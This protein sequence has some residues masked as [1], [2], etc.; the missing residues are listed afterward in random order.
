M[1]KP[2]NKRTQDFVVSL[3]WETIRKIKKIARQRSTSV[4]ALL[5]RQMELLATEDAVYEGAK[6]QALTLLDQGFHLGGAI[7][8]RRHEAHDR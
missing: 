1:T 8:V 4:G 3:D 2:R 5:A 7:R 6:R